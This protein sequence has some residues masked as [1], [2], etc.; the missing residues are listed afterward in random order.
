MATF[1]G[2]FG[3]PQVLLAVAW[4]GLSFSANAALANEATLERVQG[5][6]SKAT[7]AP[8]KRPAPAKPQ[9]QEPARK[10]DGAGNFVYGIIDTIRAQSEEL[11]LRYGNPADC[12]E[13]AEVC[14]TMHD[15]EENQVRLC[16]N[17]I[18]AD[19]DKSGSAQKSRLKR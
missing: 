11:C 8:S 18:P 15:T 19:S 3:N 13:E 7:G 1:L 16:L 5:N 10:P 9:A 12:L 17:T 2:A 4:L 6:G 14:L